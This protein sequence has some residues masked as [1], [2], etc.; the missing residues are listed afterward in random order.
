VSNKE[1]KA[2][3]TDWKNTAIGE[4]IEWFFEQ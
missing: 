1:E 2:D 3:G 4:T